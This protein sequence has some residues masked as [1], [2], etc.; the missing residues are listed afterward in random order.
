MGEDTKKERKEEMGEDTKKERVTTYSHMATVCDSDVFT[1]DCWFSG[2]SA[3]SPASEVYLHKN[4]RTL[5]SV[6]LIVISVIRNQP[7][8]YRLHCTLLI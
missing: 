2:S 7:K 6:A 5:A 4:K 3:N 8:Y 1:D